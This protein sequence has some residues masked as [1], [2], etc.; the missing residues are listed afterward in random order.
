MTVSEYNVRVAGEVY[1]RLKRW[2]SIE[3]DE[4]PGHK[5]RILDFGRRGT[6]AARTAS[7]ISTILRSSRS[8]LRPV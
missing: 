4:S 7:V 8:F 3:Y 2:M 1:D 6:A 5:R